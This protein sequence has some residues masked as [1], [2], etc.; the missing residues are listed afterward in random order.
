MSNATFIA[1]VNNGALLLAL[2]LIFDVLVLRSSL[3]KTPVSQVLLGIV[4]GVIGVAIMN[5]PWILVPGIIFD[6]RSVL[7][8]I[9]GLF[10]CARSRALLRP[11][12][13]ELHPRTGKRT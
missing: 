10:F 3:R 2:A 1:L 13:Q 11:L 9:A 7:L 8:G 12:G 5:T 6:T 4:L